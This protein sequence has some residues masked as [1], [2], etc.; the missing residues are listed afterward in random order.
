MTSHILQIRDLT[1]V[2][3]TDQ[4]P[5]TAVEAVNLAIQGDEFFTM[6]GPSGCGKTTTLRMVAGLET[7][8]SGRV[9]FD[10]QDFTKFS[11]F[12]RNIGMVFQSYAL[13][14][15][16][17]VF[18]N[19]AYGLRIRKVPE[20]EIK[21]RVGRILELLGL[22]VL[23]HR[24]PPDLSG[25]QQQRVSIARALVYDPGMLLLDEPLA[26]LDAKLRVQMRE[27]IRRIQKDLGIMSIYVT[28]DQEEAMSVSDRLAVFNL[29]RLIQVGPPH[30]VYA[31][32]RS[33]FVSDFI[34]QANFFPARVVN[35]NG[36]GARVSLTTGLEI[37]VASS[38]PLPREE[39]TMIEAGFDAVVM[40][41]PEC[42]DLG[43]A[44]SGG[45][46]CT[47]RR[48]LFLGNYTRYMLECRDSRREVFVDSPRLIPGIG[49]GCE[50]S[51]AIPAAEAILFHGGADR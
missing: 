33:L 8:T 46:P 11:T 10:D 49:E 34:G 22:D 30:E 5:V 7:I 17:T 20:A 50:A 9:L 15:H 26:N 12:Q 51:I 14:P 13:F 44:N 27:E 43:Q 23:A 45:A 18:E 35:R 31:K 24:R 16:L 39:A 40:A 32:P 36:S 3:D 28:H 38:T 37:E 48:I 25:G 19:T 21:E 4:G 1:K 42:L 41:R 2:F 47:V 6:L 29:G